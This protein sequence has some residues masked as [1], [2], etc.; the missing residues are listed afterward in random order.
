MRLPP[1][2][3]ALGAFSLTFLRTLGR[4]LVNLVFLGLALFS[5]LL[6][7]LR[8]LVLPKIEDYRPEIVAQLAAALGH[9]VALG[10][11]RAGWDGWNPRLGLTALTVQ[12]KAGEA[13]LT[14]PEV[15]A[16]LSWQSLLRFE[17]HLKSLVLERPSLLIRRTPEGRLSVGG[18]EVD[19]DTSEADPG[20]ADWL[21]R[22]RRVEIHDALLIWQ[23]DFRRAPQL[24]LDRVNFRLENRF[25]EHSFGLTGTPPP[26]VAAPLDLRGSFRGDSLA[27]WADLKGEVYLRLDYADVATWREWLPLP[28]QFTRGEGALRLWFGFARGLPRQ[29]TADLELRQ[30][31]G[32]LDAKLPELQLQRLSGRLSWRGD[33]RRQEI[34]ARRLLIEA[35]AASTPEPLDFSLKLHR[36][37]D[38][39]TGGELT[40]NTLDLAAMGILANHLPL[41]E[42]L[43]KELEARAPRGLLRQGELA[44]R[45]NFEAP[46]LA[47]IQVE[48][49][50]LGL[51]SSQGQPG[52]INLSGRVEGDARE[53]SLRLASRGGALELPKVFVSNVPFDRLDGRINWRLAKDGLV[54]QIAEAEFSSAHATGSTSGEWRAT[55]EG[56]GTIDLTA[57][58]ERADPRA[59][60]AYLPLVVGKAAREYLKH[61]LTGGAAR[62]ARLE[63]RGKLAD[64]PFDDAGKGIF[65]IRVRAEDASMDYAPG[66]PALEKVRAE[67]LFRG[68]RME[69]TSNQAEALGVKLG[70]VLVT[71]PDLG[72]DA[73]VLQV[74]GEA[75]GAT[76]DFLRFVET[77]PVLGMIDHFTEGMK[78]E[79]SGKLDLKLAIPLSQPEETKVAGE[80][81]IA[82]NELRIGGDLPPL[83][84]AT[85][86]IRFTEH[87]V[88]A[89]GINAEMLGGPVQGLVASTEGTVRISARGNADTAQLRHN[90][91]APLLRGVSG[92]ADWQA[93]VRVRSGKAQWMVDSSLRGVSLDL[94]A[95]LGKGPEEP[96][97]LHLEER[98]L[99]QGKSLFALSL[100][101]RLDAQLIRK[102]DAKTGA[103]VF[104][105]GFLALGGTAVDL[106]QPGLWVRGE[107]TDLDLDRWL[108]YR[109]SADAPPAAD[110]ASWPGVADLAGLDLKLGGL[111]LMDRRFEELR[112]AA[113]AKSGRI[114]VNLS[115]RELAG[116]L[117][118]SPATPSQPNGQLTGRFQRLSLPVASP[119]AGADTQVASDSGEGGGADDWPALDVVAE[120]FSSKGKNLGKLELKAYPEGRGWKLERL[121]LAAAEGSLEASGQWSVAARRQETLADLQLDVREAGPYLARFGMPDALKGAA[122]K[123][124]GSLAWAGPPN[125]LDYASL[126]GKLKLEVGKG[127][128]T[129]IEPGLGKLLGVLSLQALPRRLTLD[130]GDLFSSGFAFDSI[131]GDIVIERGVMST[132]RLLI[133]G[134][135]AKVELRGQAD[136]ARETQDLRVKVFPSLAT[137]AALTAG[138]A[139]NPVAG[140]VT[141][142]V[143]KMLKDPLDRLFSYE[144]QVTG[145]WS[146]PQVTNLAANTT[147]PEPANP[148]VTR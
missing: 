6:L 90:F 60:H 56:P 93:E 87:D 111:R 36:Q 110:A 19:P 3:R 140:G 125:D 101:Q 46:E 34:S 18:L 129:R 135:S 113:A 14:L 24:L 61:A 7:G 26:E 112:L 98:D 65:E 4:W 105:R 119:A 115:G 1:P 66:W 17:L 91:S 41:P 96:L 67:L 138:L 85:G 43:R 29:I 35:K 39:W 139:V 109:P 23:D 13:L 58:L 92:R 8:F 5:L 25:G 114:N 42:G 71:I 120:N 107:L 104:E 27:A 40:L 130:F 68:S 44:W 82:N 106:S 118:W 73:P 20:V 80:F 77:S 95:P 81:S 147:A 11:L 47:K 89:E 84:K 133:E 52:F 124:S 15:S 21:L 69:I 50:G 51:K 49:I 148:G 121:K 37:G 103:A 10:E 102:R 31:A 132:E 137:S 126:S 83:S 72:A 94:P 55:P 117:A 145:A 79:G 74:R 62:D 131:S 88:R 30:V 134:P 144:Y 12:G 32:R 53:G 64:F 128:F 142:L 45:G 2:R 70:N 143:S 86:K 9:P 122:A 141:W 146:D 123:L 28:A 97:P 76:A 57:R 33:E 59:V 136:I 100:G 108:D 22:Q 63:L 75:R 99:D 116:T 127:Q 38:A 78:A 16:T 48:F 54:V